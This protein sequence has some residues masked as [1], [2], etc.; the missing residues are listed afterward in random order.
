MKLF[1]PLTVPKPI[2]PSILWL[3]LKKFEDKWNSKSFK[4]KVFISKLVSNSSSSI[5]DVNLSFRNKYVICLVGSI[6]NCL[7]SSSGPIYTGYKK[8]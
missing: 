5:F 2:I 4:F 3:S 1:F 7:S 6:K 8:L